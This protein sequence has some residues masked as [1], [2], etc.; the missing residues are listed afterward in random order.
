MLWFEAR[1]GQSQGS[2]LETKDEREPYFPAKLSRCN[3][4]TIEVLWLGSGHL[5]AHRSYFRSTVCYH[6]ITKR[7]FVSKIFSI[8]YLK[9]ISDINDHCNS[10]ICIMLSNW[11]EDNLGSSWSG[12]NN[13]DNFSKVYVL[14]CKWEKVTDKDACI[15]RGREEEMLS[16]SLCH[17]C[18]WSTTSSFFWVVRWVTN[19]VLI[20]KNY[21]V[22]SVK[23][24]SS[25][26]EELG[27]DLCW[28]E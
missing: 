10:C 23:T 20:H 21:V 7:V 14:C 18:P 1:E 8:N 12:N 22:L 17:G 11:F 5:A 27:T 16:H 26:F 28:P 2:I 25:M 6:K 3:K 24:H 19:L 9:I 13:S 15:F 4:D